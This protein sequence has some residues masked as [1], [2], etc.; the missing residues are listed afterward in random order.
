MR[1]LILT[2]CALTTL[3]AFGQNEPRTLD[4]VEVL[5]EKAPSAIIEA[6]HVQVIDS[7]QIREIAAT[8]VNEL[9]EYASAVDVRQRGPRDMQ[10]D[11]SVRGGTFDQTLILVN[12]IPMNDPQT[13][14]HNMN[15]PIG[16][17][18]IDR[19]E[20]LHGGASH[21]YGPYAF[22]GAINIIT[23]NPTTN[24]ITVSAE[25]GEYNTQQAN[26]GASIHLSEKWGLRAGVG[27][28]Q[29]DGYLD[30]TDYHQLSTV[31]EL[32]YQGDNVNLSFLSGYNSKGFGAQ[33]FY[34]S[35]FP[36]QYEA[37]TTQF[38]AIRGSVL[39]NKGGI[40]F[41]LYSRQ[42]TDRFELYRETG[43]GWYE[44]NESAGVYARGTDTAA[45]WYGGPNFHRSGVEGGEASYKVIT[46]AGRTEIGFDLRNE[47]VLSNNLGLPLDNPIAVPGTRFNYTRSDSRLNSGAFVHQRYTL[48]NVIFNGSLRFNANSAFGNEWLPGFEVAYS[49]P[50]AGRVYGSYNRS[51]RL[52]TFTDLYYRLG[53]AQGSADL[54]PEYSHNYELGYKRATSKVRSSISVF[55]RDG[56]NMIDWVVLPTDT[57]GTLRAQNI[58]EL[59]IY[60][61]DGDMTINVAEET[62]NF[63]KNIRLSAAF[64]NTPT[65][66]FDF[67][68][69]YALDF[70]AAKV[71]VGM[72]HDFGK[73]FGLSWQ[74]NAQD[75]Q[76]TYVDF[77]TGDVTPYAPVVLIDARATWKRKFLTVY[78]DANNILDNVYQDRGN[79]LQPG[80][81]VRAGFRLS[82]D[83]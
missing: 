23:K 52:P 11:V 72:S 30:N 75:R 39:L 9:L 7:T 57:T 22:S 69:L 81:W 56:T 59:T 19:I 63:I 71:A 6:Q 78:V 31:A 43:E 50:N 25:Y 66:E 49:I 74:V 55:L 58:T 20:I 3:F 61:I 51:F 1:K 34:T 82:L 32:T 18:D 13:G 41:N 35:A 79:V 10:S 12:G 60:G 64:M 33:N 62:N 17:E 42:H 21:R 26:V 2:G 24:N 46:P 4:E 36:N 83:Y 54:Q 29:S 44:Y 70:L 27:V 28:G 47:R 73:G 76:G 67:E 68:S 48:G 77:G 40:N 65:G 53:G 80:R 14:H 45:V 5:G 15:L 38:H 8:T 16:V 37:T